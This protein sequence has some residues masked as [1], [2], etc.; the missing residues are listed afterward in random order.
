MLDPQ[1]DKAIV[2]KRQKQVIEDMAELEQLAKD[3]GWED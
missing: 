1:E 2:I 3:C